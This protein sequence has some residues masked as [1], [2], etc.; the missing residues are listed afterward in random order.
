MKTLILPVA[1]RSARYPGMRPKWMLTMPNGKLMIEQSVS[2]INC[3]KFDKVYV[4]ALKEHIDRYVNYKNLL[5]SLRKNISKKVEIFQL[6]KDTSCQAETIYQFLKHKKIKSSFLIKDCDNEFSI[7]ESIFR[8]KIIN[9]SVYA[10]DIKTLELIDA[11]SKSYIEKDLYN[12]VIN[13]V[14]KK[15]ISDF[16]CCGAYGFKYPK[17]F[18]SS[19]KKLLSKSKNVYISHVIL[20]LI[21]KGDNFNYHRADRYISWGTIQEYR[22]WQKKSFTIFCDFDGCLV[23]NG[24]K[25][26]SKTNKIIP[27]EKNLI[28]LKKLQDTND[29]DLIITT[30]RPL[31][32]KNK[33]KSI[34]NKYKIKYKSIITNLKHS[35]R[36][37]VNDF[38]NTNPY[39][40]SISINTERNSEEL[41]GIF[42]NLR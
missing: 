22:L 10:I 25:I 13:I 21:L 12:N 11:K 41:S 19:A 1:G 6:K 39:P 30:S 18:I 24:S 23:K 26:F 28:E 15:I 4:I 34:L 31:S 5:K 20:D 14:E 9:N 3:E 37:I 32:D 40:S 8:N 7:D 2:K 38:A 16:F 36:I 17:D 35:R 33:V 27:L 29:V 42:S